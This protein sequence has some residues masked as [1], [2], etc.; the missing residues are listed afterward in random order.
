MYDRRGLWS[1]QAWRDGV[2]REM[3]YIRINRVLGIRYG[4]YK[5]VLYIGSIIERCE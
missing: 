2:E 5:I 3:V 4:I 1:A